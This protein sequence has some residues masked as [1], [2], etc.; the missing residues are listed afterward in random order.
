MTA[1]AFWWWKLKRKREE[2]EEEEEEI[3]FGG[4]KGRCVEEEGR[5]EGT[6][7]KFNLKGQG[8]LTVKWSYSIFREVI[9]RE[10]ISRE[11]RSRMSLLG[12]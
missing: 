1:T 10:V 5:K 12:S 8:T 4:W 6:K 11:G 2:E 9:F 3:E 7:S